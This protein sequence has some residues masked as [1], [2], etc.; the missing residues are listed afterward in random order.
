[1]TP[2]LKQ[3]PNFHECRL[4]KQSHNSIKQVRHL[5][6]KTEIKKEWHEIP[7]PKLKE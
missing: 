7:A 5:S 1:M 2:K 6:T 4:L 3:Q